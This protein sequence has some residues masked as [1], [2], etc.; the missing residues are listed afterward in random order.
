MRIIDGAPVYDFA[1]Q[2]EWSKANSDESQWNAFYQRLWPDARYVLT[3]DRESQ[4]AGIDRRIVLPNGRNILVDEK[5]RS[6][7]RW[8][9]VLLE[10]WSVFYG[11]GNPRN[12]VGWSL[13][14]NKR[15]D[16]VAYAIPLLGLCYLLPFE[17]LRQT[18]IA[19]KDP[20][21]QVRSAYPLD[22][23][24]VGYRTRNCAVKWS[25]LREAM[26]VQMHRRYGLPEAPKPVQHGLFE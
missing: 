1:Q 15:V 11:V 5:L 23:Q 8:S 9:D 4:R 22:A 14:M 25:V 3:P 18:Y 7:A 16:F 21:H 2:L 17:L 13:D 20:W 19:N 12:K 10:E 26:A 6:T 24:N